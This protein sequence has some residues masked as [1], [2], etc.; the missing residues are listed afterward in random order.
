MTQKGFKVALATKNGAYFLTPDEARKK[1]DLSKPFLVGENVNK[2]VS[3][4]SGNL[5]AA[6]L[7]EGVFKSSDGGKTWK[8]S[9]KG[10]HV[11]KVWEIAVDP[12][13]KGTIFAG[14]QYGHLFKSTNHG[15]TWDE[16]E[17]LHKAPNRLN[18]GIDWGYRTAGLTLHTVKFDS[19]DPK[20]IYL[21][22]AGNG[23]YRSDD[24]GETWL[25]L[26]SGTNESCNIDPE[27]LISSEPSDS[28]PQA[29][30]KRHLAELHSD[31]HKIS[32]SARDGKLFQQNHC[33]IFYSDSH[34]DHWS[35]IS[36]DNRHRFGLPI[37]VVDAASTNVFVVP[38]SDEVP[39]DCKDHN[40]CIKGQ[41][42][43]FSSSDNGKSWKKHATGLPDNVHTTV[44]RDCL[45]HDGEKE[46]G[47]YVGT[48]TGEVYFSKDLGNTWGSIGSGVGRIQGVNVIEN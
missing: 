44:L 8:P 1:W 21:V 2:V 38:V 34:G 5:F 22:A 35:D 48:T 25:S 29:K 45:T 16:V 13:R 37:D 12:H 47:V 18:W 23:T 11:R 31:T 24:G 3:D 15:E 28:P 46:P 43:V 33:G 7:S 9:S 17:S 14:T 30:L 40:A 32:L 39:N 27:K 26:K 20:K 36:I 41:L 10:L 4:G 19:K 42:S 6:T